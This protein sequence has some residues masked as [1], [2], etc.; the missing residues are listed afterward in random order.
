MLG[1]VQKQLLII[2][3]YLI[4]IGLYL[5]IMPSERPDKIDYEL[6]LVILLEYTVS[7]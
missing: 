5:D 7:K 4:I 3:D 2:K 6:T 1:K